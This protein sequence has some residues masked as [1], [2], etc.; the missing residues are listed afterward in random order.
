ME[1]EFTN[2]LSSNNGNNYDFSQ[3]NIQPSCNV[4]ALCFLS[5]Q[6]QTFLTTNNSAKL[7]QNYIIP[8][9]VYLFPGFHFLPY[10]FL[11]LGMQILYSPCF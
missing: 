5:L 11:V 3:I 2:K 9:C 4:V 1:S 7:I 6:F 10:Q 8:V